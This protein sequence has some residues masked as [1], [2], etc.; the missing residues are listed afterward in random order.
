LVTVSV[1]KQKIKQKASRTI[2]DKLAHRS[3]LPLPL[4]LS[5]L[6]FVR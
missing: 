2:L 3:T 4:P 6:S 5:L 1:I